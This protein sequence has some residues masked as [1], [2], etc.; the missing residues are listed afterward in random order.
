[1][2][3]FSSRGQQLGLDRQEHHGGLP[4]LRGI[5]DHRQAVLGG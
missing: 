5:G 1:M 3:G 2:G 4:G